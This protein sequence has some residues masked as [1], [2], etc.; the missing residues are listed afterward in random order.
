MKLGLGTVQF[1]LDYGAT[2]R[3]GRVPETEVRAMLA[4]TTDA[5]VRLLDTANAYGEAEAVLGRCLPRSHGF[6][7]V[8]KTPPGGSLPQIEAAFSASLARL[9]MERVAG[10]LCHRPNELLAGAGKAIAHWLL[11][12]RETGRAERVGVSVYSPAEADALFARYP[13]DLVQLPLNVLDQRFLADGCLDR[14]LAQGVEIHV[15]SAFLQGLLL[16]APERLAPSFAP[17]GPAL[18]TYRQYLERQ[19][20]PPLTAALGFVAGACPA[21]TVVCGATGRSELAEIIAAAARPTDALPDFHQFARNDDP[22]I[23]PRQWKT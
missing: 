7:V 5:G 15:R 22:L 17:L 4:M 13:F 12:Q 21:A 6:S 9:D 20:I 3:A 16:E 18:S 1:G 14:L 19:G 2:N 8:T 11:D 23:D 10:L